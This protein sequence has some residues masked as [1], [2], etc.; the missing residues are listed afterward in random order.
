MKWNVVGYIVA[1]FLLLL[2]TLG[3]LVIAITQ[4]ARQEI[5]LG[6]TVIA[7]V[8]I[9]VLVLFI[10]AAGFTALGMN[11]PKEALGLPVGSVRAMIALLLIVIWIIVSIF[12]F[13]VLP[14]PS[15]TSGSTPQTND[16]K[17]QL[18]QQV[19][20]AI[21]TL[22]VAVAAFY[23]G[24]RSVAS[25]QADLAPSKPTSQPAIW[26]ID[27]PE[28]TQGTTVPLMTIQGKNF[29]LPK[30]V[31]LVQGTTTMEATEI[32]SNDTQIQCT[33]TIPATQN[34]G[35]W[36]LIVVNEDGGQDQLTGAFTV[37]KS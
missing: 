32:V 16:P 27:P 26:K 24:S 14:S 8:S 33:I 30:S 3:A 35:Q 18:A 22:V 2:L 1:A 34:V 15:T 17:V 7:G 31:R 12:L 4:N 21:G 6:L 5:T 29:R 23:F 10:M 25:A 20:T 9:L 28:G 37:I 19:E 13:T 11:D 36:D